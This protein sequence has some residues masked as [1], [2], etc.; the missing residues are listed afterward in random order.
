MANELQNPK[1]PKTKKT[2]APK[3][4]RPTG[5]KKAEESVEAEVAVLEAT[6]VVVVQPQPV[7]TVASLPAEP[8]AVKEGPTITPVVKPVRAESVKS[9]RVADDE[10]EFEE[11][12]GEPDDP[13]AGK[14][15]L[16]ISRA[17]YFRMKYQAKEEGLSLEEFATELLAEG[18]VLRAWEIIEKKGQMRGIPMQG[19]GNGP[20]NA[21]RNNQQSGNRHNSNNSGGN[22]HG[23]GHRKN[24]H[25]GMSQSRYQSIMDDKANFLEYVRNQERNRR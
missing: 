15:T 16:Q 14:L 18:A 10:D 22:N 5:A 9:A 7:V 24:G 8:K 23:G 1:A 25:R 4:S 6:P 17:L 2:A 12:P 20:G 21:H 3:K 19:N 13:N 11:Q